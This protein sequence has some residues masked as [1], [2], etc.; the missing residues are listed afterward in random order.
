[1]EKEGEQTTET[2]ETM[3][4]YTREEATAFVAGNGKEKE[5]NEIILMGAMRERKFNWCAFFF[6]FIYSLYRKCYSAALVY[7]AIIVCDNIIGRLMPDKGAGAIIGTII[8]LALAV[9]CGYI[10]YPF[11]RKTIAAAKMKVED[12]EDPEE[13]AIALKK[14]GGVSKL[15]MVIGILVFVVLGVVIMLNLARVAEYD[16]WIP[17]VSAL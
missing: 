6:G 7:A 1:M 13:K 17:I 15:G 3:D 9:I 8:S 10:F 12:I 2:S 11:Y 4:G 16:V 14:L 5:S